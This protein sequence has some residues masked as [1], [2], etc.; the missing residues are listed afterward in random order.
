MSNNLKKEKVKKMIKVYQ[1]IEE[2]L[3]SSEGWVMYEGKSLK[4]AMH[5]LDQ[6]YIK[7]GYIQ[8]TL[9]KSLDELK[10]NGDLFTSDDNNCRIIKVKGWDL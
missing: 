1:V 10:D 4:K 5:T 9:V 7:K 3:K 8:S 2:E 6:Y